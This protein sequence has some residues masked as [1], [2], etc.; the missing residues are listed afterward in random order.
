MRCFI[1]SNSL[2]GE[3]T[4]EKGELGEY[5]SLVLYD[6]LKNNKITK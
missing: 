2:K 3:R 6:V 1:S 4:N 5:N